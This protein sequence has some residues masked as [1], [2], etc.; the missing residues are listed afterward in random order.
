MRATIVLTVTTHVDIDTMEVE[1]EVDL[2]TEDPLPREVV[3]A[4][5]VGGCR[6]ALKALR[7]EKGE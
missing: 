3:I 2:A 4:A 1:H 7:Q 6:S 5:A